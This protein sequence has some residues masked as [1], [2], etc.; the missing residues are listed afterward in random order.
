MGFLTGAIDQNT[1]FDGNKAD[2]RANVPR[3]APDALKA[4]MA[5]VDVVKTWA[6][7]KEATPAQISLAWLS[8]QKPWIVPIPG[9]TNIKHMEENIGAAQVKFT[10]DELKELTAAVDAIKI[11]GDRL[12]EA[13]LAFSGVEAPPKK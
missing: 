10:A 8:A 13:V 4:N 6:Q 9:T 5:L 11:Q 12:P 1:R 3:F 7:K 2:F